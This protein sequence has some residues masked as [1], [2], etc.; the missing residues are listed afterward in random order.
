MNYKKVFFGL[1]SN[2][3]NK[4]QNLLRAAEKLSEFIHNI[5]ISSVYRT[6]PVGPEQDDFYNAVLSGETDLEP[7]KLLEL[8]KRIEREMGRIKS[9]H[10]G[11]RIIDVD[12]LWVEDTEIEALNLS[13]PH[14]EIT[15]R[16]FVLEPLYELAGNIYLREKTLLYYL[17]ESLEQ[18]CEK[19]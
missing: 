7:F 8:I 9:F 11:P 15:Y 2:L 19:K 10:W 13:I 3:G 6:S 18:N 16:R 14:R 17:N 12:I 5:S 1:G 4:K